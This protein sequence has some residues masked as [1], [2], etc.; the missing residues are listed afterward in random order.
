[1]GLVAVIVLSSQDNHI[2]ALKVILRIIR[3][4]GHTTLR[5]QKVI[6]ILLAYGF[7][8]GQV[9]VDCVQEL[10]SHFQEIITFYGQTISKLKP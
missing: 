5:H 7:L 6:A 9:Q 3:V 2:F 8:F 4:I 1:M 10:V